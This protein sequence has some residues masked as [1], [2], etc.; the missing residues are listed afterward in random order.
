MKRVFGLK[1]HIQ[2]SLQ[3]VQRF[4]YQAEHGKEFRAF[5]AGF[6]LGRAHELLH[7]IG[8]KELWWGRFEPLV[9]DKKWVELQ[10]VIKEYLTV[11][12]LEHPD[13]AFLNK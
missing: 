12:G 9:I 5:Q 3:Q 11:L 1:E 7:G 2:H 8:E 4:A 10:T 6:N 13:L